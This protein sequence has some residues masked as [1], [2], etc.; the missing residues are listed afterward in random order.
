MALLATSDITSE[1]SLPTSFTGPGRL[2]AE[3]PKGAEIFVV[4][5]VPNDANAGVSSKH[6]FLTELCSSIVATDD[7][8]F[9]EAGILA[10]R[11]ILENAGQHIS[12]QVWVDVI[13]AVTSISGA[14]EDASR[15]GSEWST[16]SATAFSCVKLIV[17]D[18]LDQLPPTSDTSVIS[19]RQAL[20]DCCSSFGRSRH[21]LNT[22]LT[23]IGLLWTIADQD[24]DSASVDRALSMLV[25]LSSDSRPEVRN[26]AVNT[27][28]SC[29][30]GRGQRFSD[31]QWET[32]MSQIVFGAYDG[33]LAHQNAT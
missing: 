26:C 25:L 22:S 7:A 16:C 2:I 21:D 12:G 6:A 29:V 14:Q 19:P 33:I 13:N 10:V 3:N 31:Q 27:L 15:T 17:D 32:C 9:A 4:V 18:F 24:S 23:S 20:F 30:V 5:A 1:P 28:F 11:S 8:S